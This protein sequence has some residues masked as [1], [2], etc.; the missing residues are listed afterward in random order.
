M[1]IICN[2][3][4]RSPCCTASVLGRLEHKFGNVGT[5]SIEAE[6]SWLPQVAIV[7][8]TG[9]RSRVAMNP[10]RKEVELE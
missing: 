10:N 5:C 3:I 8:G 9:T 6:C 7:D 2:R 4:L 1:Q